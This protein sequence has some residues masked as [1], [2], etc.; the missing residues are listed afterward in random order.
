MRP[1]L[2][3]EL[4]G[5]LAAAAVGAVLASLLVSRSDALLV[6]VTIAT[7]AILLGRYRRDYSRTP[8]DEVAAALA[9]AACAALPAALLLAAAGEPPWAAIIVAPVWALLAGAAA[10]TTFARRRVCPL[11]ELIAGAGYPRRKRT[12]AFTEGIV[13][14]I[15]LVV[16]SVLLVLLAPLLLLIA[17]LIWREDGGAPLFAQ[18]RVGRDDRP[19]VMWKFR[20]MRADADDAWARPGDRRITRIGA[21][22]RRSSLDE[23][24]QLVNVLRGEMS[25]VGPR[26]EMREYALRFAR[27]RSEYP[28]RHLVRPGITGWAQ[29]QLPRNL[30]PD[31]MPRVL[32]CDLYYVRN[33][34]VLLYAFCMA[35]TLLD[36]ARHDAV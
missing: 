14:S 22:L 13:R 27:E 20:T 5:D 7:V 28:Y 32:G 29:L 33:E 31:D 2:P 26:P 36:V 24:P 3:L 34:S 30:R 23:L 17:L 12:A 18:E 35:K 9:V 19:F 25:L 4:L 16:A 1:G 8:R 10:A 6:L 11:D 15:D 21:M